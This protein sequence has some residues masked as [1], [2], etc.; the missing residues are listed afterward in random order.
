MMANKSAKRKFRRVYINL[1]IL[2]VVVILLVTVA[3]FFIKEYYPAEPVS[4]GIFPDLPEWTFWADENV[5][6]TP[7]VYSSYVFV[8][9]SEAVYK[10]AGDSGIL[11]WRFASP[12]TSSS[13][14]VSPQ[15]SDNLLIIPE[16]GGLLAAVS[17]DTGHRVWRIWSVDENRNFS[18]TMRIE[19]LRIEGGII[20]VAR[21]S[22]RLTAYDLE[23]GEEL[24][25]VR[26]PDRV[27]LSLATD[28]NAVY[29][30]AGHSIYAYDLQYGHLLW[31]KYMG[32][33]VNTFAK[34]KLS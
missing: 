34:N 5:T 4:N 6:A 30:G 12:G 20:Y 3:M 29:L 23:S 14:D 15:I 28:H 26:V 32:I 16:R 33:Y 2:F 13:L 19:A 1:G 24:W 10:V 27:T 31:E 8:R 22:W 11:L 17:I 21:E 25:E 9:T 7:V 18:G